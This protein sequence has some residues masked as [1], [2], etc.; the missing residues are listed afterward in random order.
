MVQIFNI[1]G[2]L[3]SKQIFTGLNTL[4]WRPYIT[5][6]SKYISIPY[7]LSKDNDDIEYSSNESDLLSIQQLTIDWIQYLKSKIV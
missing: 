7:D 4:L 5:N 2:K 6:K 1:D 3:C